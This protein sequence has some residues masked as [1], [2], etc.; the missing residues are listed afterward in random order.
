MRDMCRQEESREESRETCG[1]SHRPVSSL[2]TETV[3]SKSKTNTSQVN[4][5]YSLGRSNETI[6]L[7]VGLEEKELTHKLLL[8]YYSSSLDQLI[9]DFPAN[10][11]APTIIPLP[12]LNPG[13]ASI[14]RMLQCFLPSNSLRLLQMVHRSS[15]LNKKI[16]NYEV[17]LIIY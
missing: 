4:I 7:L 10:G 17:G 14:F 16:Q 5:F 6:T 3:D 13:L 2:A 15:Y 8:G 1:G 12:D 9:Y 11:E